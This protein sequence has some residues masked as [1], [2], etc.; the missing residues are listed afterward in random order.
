M[1]GDGMTCPCVP[2]IGEPAVQSERVKRAQLRLLARQFRQ[3][4][5]VLTPD[6]E[7]AYQ[8]PK[9][10]VGPLVFTSYNGLVVRHL[11]YHIWPV[12]NGIWRWNVDRLCERMDVFNGRR[13]IGIAVD[14]WT[15]AA[16]TVMEYFAEKLGPDHRIE[17]LVKDNHKKLGEVV[18]FPHLIA[19]LETTATN[20]IVFYGHAKAVRR[21]GHPTALKWTEAMY[22]TLF[23]NVELVEQLL[24]SHAFAGSFRRTGNFF[25]SHGNCGWHYSGTFWWFRSRFIFQRDWRRIAKR[26][27]G[28]ESW[29][30]MEFQHNESACVFGDDAGNLYRQLEWDVQ[31]AALQEWRASR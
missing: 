21:E 18:T 2:D 17:F 11:C 27:G 1:E 22:E 31:E 14:Q 12:Q 15:N 5:V 24:M 3:R 19:A 16:E 28:V 23:D 7:P 9:T 25:K 29:P 4:G 30:G 8:P 26:Y 6:R 13:R 10:P 20:E